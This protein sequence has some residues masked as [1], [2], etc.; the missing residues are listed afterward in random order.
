MKRSTFDWVMTWNE[1]LVGLVVLV[2]LL[3]YP[4]R[5]LGLTLIVILLI[6][7]IRLA[8]WDALETRKEDDPPYIQALKAASCKACLQN[9]LSWAIHLVGIIRPPTRKQL[10][11]RCSCHFQKV[12]K[13]STTTNLQ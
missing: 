6:R 8:I 2:F 1:I 12:E 7:P 9:H 10:I 3:A 4:S 13:H 11:C 5:K